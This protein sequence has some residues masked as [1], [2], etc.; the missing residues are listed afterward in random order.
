MSLLSRLGKN[1]GAKPGV[2]AGGGELIALPPRARARVLASRRSQPREDK[3]ARV[4]A[5]LCRVHFRAAPRISAPPGASQGSPALL[6]TAP[7]SLQGKQ[8]TSPALRSSGHL[9]GHA[10]CPMGANPRDTGPRTGHVN[11]D[12]LVHLQVQ[13]APL[14]LDLC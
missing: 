6:G 14:A 4:S 5:Q 11:P 9:G 12:S 1:F 13:C 10:A 8:H 7:H 2:C 3:R